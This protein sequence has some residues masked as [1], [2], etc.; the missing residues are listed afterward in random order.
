MI[1]IDPDALGLKLPE[2]LSKSDNILGNW[3]DVNE[4]YISNSISNSNQNFITN[5]YSIGLIIFLI[6]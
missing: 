3:I 4:F 1:S 5:I 6:H 2:N